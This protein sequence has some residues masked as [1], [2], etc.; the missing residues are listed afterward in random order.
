MDR[1]KFLKALLTA[2]AA[3]AVADINAA[4]DAA[5]KGGVVPPIEG[6][7][8]KLVGNKIVE[9][10]VSTYEEY[11]EASIF[12]PLDYVYTQGLLCCLTDV[13]DEFYKKR[14]IYQFQLVPQGF[15]ENNLPVV[16]CY[17]QH[18]RVI[19]LTSLT[20][21]QI[22]TSRACSNKNQNDF[23]TNLNNL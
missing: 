21:N 23:D 1:R 22:S 7:K 4:V 3:S 18:S 2:A 5:T 6:V 10:L 16:L 17:W 20:L 12:E 8:H 9:R 11:I 13:L 19:S 15:A 14:A